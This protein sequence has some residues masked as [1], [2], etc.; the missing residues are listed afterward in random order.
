MGGRYGLGSKDTRPSQIL[1]VFNNLKATEPKNGFT[2]G[3]VDDVTNTSL[4]EAEAIETNPPGTIRCKFWGLGSDG[5]VG[6]NKTAIKIIGDNTDLY[7][8]AYF[9]YDS[10]KSGGSTISHLRFGKNPIKSP[11]LV[12]DSDYVACHNKSFIYNFDLLK[13]LKK[14]GTF[15]LNCPWSEEELDEKLPASLK[16]YIAENSINFY[17]I[18][19]IDIAQEIGLGGRINM[20]MQS[21]FFKLAN[22]I[23]V[24]EAVKYLKNSVEKTY[25][26]KGQKIVDMNKTAID[27]GI[28]AL[29]KVSVPEGWK[30]AK[31]DKSH[32]KQEPA[33]VKNIQRPMARHEGDELPVSAFNGIEDGTFPL[34]ST[35]Y[36]KR[37]I[38]VMIPEWQID[39]C[40]QCNQ[41]S[42]V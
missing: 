11:Y 20:V 27:R 12:Y 8:Q 24:D 22:V 13:G 3:I 10:K 5:T 41:C 33:F 42:Y 14:G 18:D 29:H 6:A 15:V 17:T 21:A 35:A 31:E 19:A 39:K 2:I 9:S 16:R 23:P 26:R 32:E 40:I 38:A 28:E 30:E 1:A 37:G 4:P 36:E 7:V 25:G 34:G